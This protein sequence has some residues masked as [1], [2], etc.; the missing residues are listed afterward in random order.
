M[1]DKSPPELEP[2][3]R[4]NLSNHWLCL[5]ELGRQGKLP[6]DY[7]REKASAKEGENAPQ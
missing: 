3:Q 1:T 7:G 2:W 6:A 5:N 4:Q